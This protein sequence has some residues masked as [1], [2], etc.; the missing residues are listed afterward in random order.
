MAHAAAR[1]LGTPP[2]DD[3]AAA[4]RNARLLFCIGQTRKAVACIRDALSRRA[5]KT[6]PGL[7]LIS[8]D[9]QRDAHPAADAERRE[10]AL[11]IAL[12]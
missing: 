8:F 2:P 4:C 11:R 1:R 6:A 12:D 10:P 3:R 5:R 7:L 9:R